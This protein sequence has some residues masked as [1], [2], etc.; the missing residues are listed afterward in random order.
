MSRKRF[1]VE[2]TWSGYRASQ[3]HIVHR[4]VIADYVAKRLGKV[5]TIGFTDGTTMS[6]S[7]RPCNLR[8]KV[9]EIK[10]YVWL[11]DKIAWAD[12]EGYV[13]VMEVE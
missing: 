9:Q 6:V 1:I 2:C 8:E 5:H 13:S 11:L 10:G 12:K 4:T 3:A 7:V